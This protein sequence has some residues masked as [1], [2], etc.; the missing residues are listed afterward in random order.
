L[1]YDA[2]LAFSDASNGLPRSCAAW[3]AEHKCIAN[4]TLVKPEGEWKVV[5]K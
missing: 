2:A 3:M 1:M 4:R 5:M